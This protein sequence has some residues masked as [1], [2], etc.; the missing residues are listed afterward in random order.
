MSKFIS[1]LGPQMED[2]LNYREALGYSPRTYLGTLSN[3]D[4]FFAANYP[5][6]ETLTSD[7]V[8]EWINEQCAG[9]DEKVTALR[10][11]GSY[12]LSIGKEAYVV[13]KNFIGQKLDGPAA[14][15][16]F[17]DEELRT[18][19]SAA[20][21]FPAQ[22]DQPFLPE[23]V[24]VMFRLIYTCGLR[25]NEGRELKRDNV[26][27]KTGEILITHTKRKK[28]RTVVMSSDM[29]KLA[30]HYDEKRAIFARG[31]EYFFPSWEG[32]AFTNKQVGRYFRDCWKLAN[33]DVT[34]LP[35][36]R[37]Y[38]LRHRFASAV[39]IRWLDSGQPLMVKLPY[40][41]AYMGHDN[42]TETLYYVHLL[43]E[44]LIKATGIDWAAFDGIVPGVCI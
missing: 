42:I 12:L 33:P 14:P 27:L 34:N 28:E 3:I 23:I 18:L 16:M 1:K 10:V 5:D 7:I 2:M 31:S 44:N 41:R 30:K 38:D 22:Y 29:S 13:P 36:V 43:P 6:A 25:P 32:S 4:R 9:I 24:P 11:F 8:S 37:V 20:D 17:N 15:Y 35:N 26:N 39:M 19:F 21:R 40:L